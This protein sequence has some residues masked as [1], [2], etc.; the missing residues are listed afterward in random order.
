MIDTYLQSLDDKIKELKED[1]WESNCSNKMIVFDLLEVMDNKMTYIAKNPERAKAHYSD[2]K[3]MGMIKELRRR[4]GFNQEQ[5]AD[6]IGVTRESI[7]HWETGRRPITD[8]RR[9]QFKELLKQYES[10]NPSIFMSFDT[11]T[12]YEKIHQELNKHK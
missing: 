6:F 1:L 3:D 7:S 12:T 8:I 4:L 10:P 5:L 9:T 11:L 2:N